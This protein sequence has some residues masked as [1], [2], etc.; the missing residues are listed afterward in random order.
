MPRDR[1]RGRI[2]EIFMVLSEDKTAAQTQQIHDFAWDHVTKGL[3][4][5]LTCS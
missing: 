2:F 3:G 4:C 5:K 1:G